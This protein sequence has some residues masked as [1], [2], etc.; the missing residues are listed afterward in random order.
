MENYLTTQE[1][2]KMHG[3]TKGRVVQWITDGDLPATKFNQVWAVKKEDAESF[4]RKPIP[5]RPAK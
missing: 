4:V 1:V 3:V 2:A 5:G